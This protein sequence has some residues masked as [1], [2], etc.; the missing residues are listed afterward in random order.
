MIEYATTRKR[1]RKQP[2][3]EWCELAALAG[4]FLIMGWRT[5]EFIETTPGVQQEPVGS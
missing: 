1:F 3:R 2:T 4:G 5:I